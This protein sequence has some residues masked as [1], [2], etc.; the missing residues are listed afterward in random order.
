MPSIYKIPSRTEHHCEPCAFHK[1]TG[2]LFVRC[3]EGSWIRYACTH[4]DAFSP[5]I[6][7]RSMFA[8]EGRDIGKTEE[9]PDW[10]PLKRE[11]SRADGA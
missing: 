7:S 8:Q 4:P 11:K 1:R 10:C 3:G 6:R 9:Q 5:P 2:A